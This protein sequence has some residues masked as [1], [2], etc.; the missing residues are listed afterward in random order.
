[1]FDY[2]K[3]RE[4]RRKPSSHRR[5]KM[6]VWAKVLLTIL[7]LVVVLAGSAYG[8]VQYSL[9]KI[10]KVD[11]KEE[12]KV[13][14]EEETFEADETLP[15]EEEVQHMDPEDVVWVGADLDVMKDK[16]VVNILLIGQDRREGESRQRSDSMILATLNKK[17]SSISLTSFMRDLYVQIP[18]YS[19]NRINAA[20]AF[21]GMELLDSTIETNFGVHIDGNV[22]VDFSGF[23]ILIDKLG[24]ID[25]ELNQAEADYI[26]GRNSNV[27]YPQ[28]NRSDWNLTAGMNHLTGEQALIHARNRSIG[29]SDY[30]RTERQRSVLTAAFDKMK[31]SDP[32]TIVT[33][34]NEA[35]PLLTTDL[36]SQTILGYAME[37]VKMG[38]GDVQSYR[39]PIDG[40]YTPAV[41]RQM[42][43]LVPDLQKNQEYL[44]ETLYSE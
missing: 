25:M 38:I 23:Q 21:G 10:N 44:K 17:N 36:D 5:K 1:M 34:I 30:A 32:A 31:S 28:E 35:L 42:Q 37:I 20:Y 9:S 12:V 43:V 18:G 39:V 3:K 11:P 16:D 8:Y 41:I 33:L 6:P 26:C 13:A 29:N 24:G 40:A 14:P 15:S 4:R 22:E 2:H 19:D 7:I 27:L